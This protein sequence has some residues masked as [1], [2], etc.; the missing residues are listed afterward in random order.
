M[1]KNKIQHIVLKSLKMLNML[2]NI[3]PSLL[4]AMTAQK[5]PKKKMEKK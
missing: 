2:G 4:I 1:E 3:K 5:C